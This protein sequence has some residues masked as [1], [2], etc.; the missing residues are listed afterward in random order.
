[1]RRLLICACLLAAASRA[2]EIVVVN[3]DPPESGL[4][5][6][7]PAAPVGGNLAI[8]LG[9]QR[10][11]VLE[12]A[13]RMWGLALPGSVPVKITA[14]FT[15]LPCVSSAAVLGATKPNAAFADF[16]GAPLKQT[17]YPK[18]LADQLA[19]HEISASSTAM[20]VRLNVRLGQADCL[21]GYPFY[22]GLD[23]AWGASISL[24]DVALH[25][26]AHGL[27]FVSGADSKGAF[28]GWPWIYDRN[29]YDP[30]SGQTWDRLATD[31]ERVAAAQTTVLSWDGPAA[32]RSAAPLLKRTPRL[33]V[34]EG[35]APA[36]YAV[37]TSYLG[38]LPGD[39]GTSGPIVAAA[40][41]G[42]C[43]PLFEDL[44]GKIALVERSGCGT[45]SQAKG[46]QSAGAIGVLVD[47]NTSG[48]AGTILDADSSV[49]IPVLPLSREDAAAVRG[50]L[51]VRGTLGLDTAARQGTDAQ[52]R[53]ALYA[54][55]MYAPGSS[56]S[57]LGTGFSLPLL[58]QPSIS[59]RHTLGV[60][61]TP[62]V[63]RDLGWFAL[64]VGLANTY[65]LP[66]AAHSPGKNGAFYTTDL[67]LSNRGSNDA[68]VVL[69]FLGHDR[70]GSVGPQ[71][72][73][74]LAAGRTETYRD[75]LGT[76]FGAAS[77]G[78][79]GA[80]LVLSDSASLRG[81]GIT[82]TPSPSG[83]TFGHAVPLQSGS[84]L[85]TPLTPKTI[86]GLREDAGSRTNAVFVNL[87]TA[88]ASV[89][90]ALVGP[91]G[92]TLGTAR[93]DLLPLQMSQVN[94]LPRAL[95]GGGV[96]GAALV[97]STRSPGAQIATYATVIDN[98]TNDP[99]ALLP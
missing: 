68:T 66:S 81:V 10:L 96:D 87:T 64:P 83:G 82:A 28:A 98:V 53:I 9:A 94:D 13:A 97:V 73:L 5:D 75:V 60:D 61:I 78:D 56:V 52:G 8:T 42:G 27:G 77:G 57:H 89:D 67:T 7:T 76:K 80:V 95:G 58:M 25:E 35:S 45:K 11:A 6:P 50:S 55:P 79:Y 3:A 46:L 38:P 71:A 85:V 21:A 93:L 17:G 74:T 32:N 2:A 29:V 14:T 59:S 70:D 47:W 63:F 34:T 36:A 51:P 4:N 19:G 22:L 65:V 92:A 41:H 62:S 43:P 48:G 44:S 20:D 49:K 54:P 84:D 86:L 26:F 33:F 72:S 30:A 37:G 88:S 91:D 15:T 23:G 24:L 99:K 16:A 1:M 90:L 12:E 40:D 18:A 31:A 39:P 69:Q